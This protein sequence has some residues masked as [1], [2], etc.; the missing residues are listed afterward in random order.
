MR[1]TSFDVCS[2]PKAKNCTS[3][4]AN[5]TSKNVIYA[6]FQ[7]FKTCSPVKGKILSSA[8]GKELTRLQMNK[9]CEHL[10]LKPLFTTL[11]NLTKNCLV[12]KLQPGDL[13][14]GNLDSEKEGSDLLNLAPVSAPTPLI[15][16]D[17]FIDSGSFERL[18][19]CLWPIRLNSNAGSISSLYDDA[20]TLSEEAASPLVSG[21]VDQSLCQLAEEF[22]CARAPRTERLD[23]E[24][25]EQ[26]WRFH[27]TLQDAG[28][29]CQPSCLN[30][31][32]LRQ[33]AEEFPCAS[34]TDRASRRRRQ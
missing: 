17:S 18:L 2:G 4:R 30:A 14:K 19:V 29:E 5:I 31:T 28:E 20:K 8:N 16:S 22:P 9:P 3:L 1:L 7:V 10:F 12:L 15:N 24:G 13:D 34:T 33:L 27:T 23:A 26:C 11:F 25:N 21:G 32:S 6:D